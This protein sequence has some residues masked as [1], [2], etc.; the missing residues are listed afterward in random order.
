MR[1]FTS[2][3]SLGLLMVSSPGWAADPTVAGNTQVGT[4]PSYGANYSAFWRTGGDYALLTDNYHAYINAPNQAGGVYVRNN[5][6]DVAV[7]LR[8]GIELQKDTHFNGWL[9]THGSSSF[10]GP[11]YSWDSVST[12]GD[13]FVNGKSWI[14]GD[15]TVPAP[16][17]FYGETTL[18]GRTTLSGKTYL[19]GVT[20]AYG[21]ATLYSGLVVENSGEGI[22][23]RQ[24]GP[25][26]A[27]AISLVG[28]GASLSADG[29]IYANQG[30]KPGGGPW[31]STSDRRVKKDVVEFRSGLAEVE[32][33][34]AVR[35]KYNGLA[36]TVNSDKEYVGVIAQ[37][38]EKVAPYMVS[39]RQKKL[40]PTDAAPVDLKEVDANA[41]TYML[42]NA[43]QELSQ[44]N[45]EM[46]RQNKEMKKLLC[47]DHPTA[48]LCGNASKTLA[49]K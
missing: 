20:E 9:I 8:D 5:N 33:V 27:Y 36:G 12:Y 48:A 28:P 30:L 23:V 49:R 7:F 22:T 3:I 34:R 18:A 29:D 47:Q 26:G 1:K 2:A 43:V 15:L 42:V 31:Q 32:Q 6:S 39:S 41:F 40:H 11:I 17:T 16:S 19:T 25:T 24:S 10:N 45:K 4:H 13:L 37:E 44:Q 46:A 14:Y 21:R 35:F 38:I